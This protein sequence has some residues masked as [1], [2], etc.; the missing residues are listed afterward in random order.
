MHMWKI[1]WVALWMVTL[2]LGCVS[3]IPARGPHH[4]EHLL[5]SPWWARAFVATEE[6]VVPADTRLQ[7]QLVTMQGRVYRGIPVTHPLDLL[8]PLRVQPATEFVFGVGVSEDAKGTVTVS[9]SLEIP[10]QGAEPVTLVPETTVRFPDTASRTV[11]WFRLSLDERV[12]EWARLRIHVEPTGEKQPRAWLLDPVLVYTIAPESPWAPVESPRTALRHFREQSHRLHTVL[13]VADRLSMADLNLEVPGQTP[14][15]AVES[16]MAGAI[17][18][19]HVVPVFDDANAN[20]RAIWA[21]RRVG[22][23]RIPL[24]VVFRRGLYRTT[25]WISSTLQE[26][27]GLATAVEAETVPLDLAESTDTWVRKILDTLRE[28]HRAHRK[29]FLALITR[30]TDPRYGAQGLDTWVHA[31]QH[32]IQ[33]IPEIRARLNLC[34]LATGRVD[35]NRVWPGFLGC[36]PPD[37]VL[38]PHPIVRAPISGLDVVPT[39]ADWIAV[40][41]K[42]A[43][44]EGTSRLAWV[45]YREDPV[46]AVA[47]GWTASGGFVVASDGV[48][49]VRDTKVDRFEVTH[50]RS[51]VQVDP[52]FRDFYQEFLWGQWRTRGVGE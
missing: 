43:D 2:A 22:H 12:R 50:P 6:S 19:D 18:F 23:S 21:G 14:W 47:V 38:V 25:V 16:F 35:E 45:F 41:R 7:P 10:R 26:I 1:R 15:P 29:V 8:F 48:L 5:T 52:V 30:L 3:G 9:V 37:N 28:A 17:R 11:R 49:W 39:W 24:P 20:L 27:P 51:R 40:S 32:A 34:I 33:S 42:D 13:L 4:T 46:D 31:F 44:W 36:R